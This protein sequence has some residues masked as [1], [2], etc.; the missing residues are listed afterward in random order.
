MLISGLLSLTSTTLIIILQCAG[1]EFGPKSW[2]PEHQSHRIWWFH[3]P[4][5]WKESNVLFLNQSKSHNFGRHMT[6]EGI[7]NFPISALIW[8]SGIQI[9]EQR[10]TNREFSKSCI[11]HLRLLLKSRAVV[12]R[13]WNT[14][15]SM[16]EP[17]LWGTPIGGGELKLIAWLQFRS[18]SLT[19]MSSACFAPSVLV[20]TSILKKSLLERIIMEGIFPNIWIKCTV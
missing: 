11:T 8:I 5:A 6:A 20:R 1:I 4:P 2:E 12:I 17:D 3:N 19:T 15:F 16:D 13:V 7:D 18:S 14:D 10:D 9:K